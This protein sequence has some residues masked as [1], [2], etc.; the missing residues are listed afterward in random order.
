MKQIFN[1]QRFLK[2]SN[3]QIYMQSRLLVYVLAGSWATLLLLIL[4]LFA[5]N[6]G[7]AAEDWPDLFFSTGI[8]AAIIYSGTAFPDLRKKETFIQFLMLPASIFEKFLYEFILRIILF[9]VIYPVI[10][11]LAAKLAIFIF[12]KKVGDISP[13]FFYDSKTLVVILSFYFFLSAIFFAGAS[14]VR[15]S[16]LLKTMIAGAL[17]QLLGV[18]YIILMEHFGIARG[19]DRFITVT[20]ERAIILTSGFLLFSGLIAFIFA[21]FKIKEKTE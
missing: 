15:K 19:I 2:Y 7:W 9:I 8:F 11:Y 13:N 5:S 20:A 16:P 21:Y 12:P 18:S 6:H 3:Y 10:F 4:F 14:F 1:I 17:F